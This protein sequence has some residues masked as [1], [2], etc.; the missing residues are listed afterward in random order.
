MSYADYMQMALYDERFG[1]YMREREKIGKEGDFF[2]NG[3]LAAVFGKALAS[4]WIRLVERGGCRR[5]FANGGR[6]RASSTG[7]IGRMEEKSP[8]TY[9]KLSYTIIDQSP[10]HR[11]RQRN[12]AS[13]RGKSE[14]I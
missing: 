12:A 11:R 5:P 13:G 9:Q 4:F 8:H 14:T 3:S 2:T 7:R 6:G 1:Y 10:F